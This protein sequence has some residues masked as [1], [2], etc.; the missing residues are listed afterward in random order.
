VTP[1][2]EDNCCQ[3]WWARPTAVRP[4]HDLLLDRKE[5]DRRQ[6]LFRKEDRERFT[7]AAALV[8]LVLAHHLNSPAHQLRLD[9]T[10]PTCGAWHG[11]PRL[12]DDDSGLR[13]SISHAGERIAV[14]V[15]RGALVGVDVEQIIP[16]LEIDT[17]ASYVLCEDERDLLDRLPISDRPRGL[18]TYWTRKEALLKATA[19]GLRVP[20]DS[21]SVSGPDES[22]F[23]RS[24][25]APF[26]LPTPVILH[27]LRPGAGYVASLAVLGLPTIRVQELDAGALLA[28]GSPGLLV[29]Q[30]DVEIPSSRSRDDDCR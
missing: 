21:V 29:P 27:M 9:R 22:P 6:R 30:A 2:L 12:S 10:C 4:G 13:V 23:L 20:M 16:T 18:L 24:W 26:E 5:L 25:S 28:T 1:S 8:R 17:L 19:H 3:V 15:V 14:S 7:V 11:P